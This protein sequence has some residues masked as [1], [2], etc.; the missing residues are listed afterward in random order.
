M[1]YAKLMQALKNPDWHDFL[2]PFVRE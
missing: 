2:R 1:G